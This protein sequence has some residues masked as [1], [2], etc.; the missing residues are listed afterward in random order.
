MPVVLV[1]AAIEDR[2]G[3]AGCAGALAEH[4]TAALRALAFRD[5]AQL[6]LEPAHGRESRAAQ[7]VDQLRGQ[8]AV[9]P[10]HRHAGPRR[11]ARDLRA[12]A[13]PPFQPLLLFGEDGHARLP[14]L[15][16]TY[17]PS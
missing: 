5:R 3:D 4:L 2:L 7:I 13:P 8:P 11:G 12:H 15:R 1:A 6:G 17:S 10:E 9:G 14:T 16:A